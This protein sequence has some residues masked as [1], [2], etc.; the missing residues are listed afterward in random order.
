MRPITPAATC[1][2]KYVANF[3]DD[4]SRMKKIFFKSKK[5]AAESNPPAQYDGGYSPRPL[6]LTSAVKQRR[7]V[8]LKGVSATLFAS[9]PDGEHW[10]GIAPAE[11]SVGA[12]WTDAV[13]HGQVYSQAQQLPGQQVGRIIHYAALLIQQIASRSSGRSYPF[14]QNAQQGGGTIIPG[15]VMSHGRRREELQQDPGGHLLPKD[16]GAVAVSECR[17]SQQNLQVAEARFKG[18]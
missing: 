10:S 6:H 4:Y 12:D 3:T 7:R 15:R 18:R 13:N 9:T 16:A 1:G 2:Y 14:P 17:V 11:R 5:E 8:H